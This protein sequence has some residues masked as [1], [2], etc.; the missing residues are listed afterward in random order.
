MKQVLE[1]V[2][3]LKGRFSKVFIA[4]D[5]DPKLV[6]QKH[7]RVGALLAIG[8]V[9]MAC[10]ILAYESKPKKLKEIGASREISSAPIK[11][12]DIEEL[13]K[14]TSN[15]KLWTEGAS[16]EVEAVKQKQMLSEEEQSKLK[17]YIEKDKVS[18]DE[19]NETISQ[20]KAQ[21]EEEYSHKMA[22][23]IEQ[24]KNSTEAKAIENPMEF[25]SFTN[26][27]RIK[28]VGSYIPAGSFVEGKI[29]AGVD[30]SVGMTA[31]ADP[32]IV[33]IR[34]TGKVVSA[35]TA[36]QNNVS[37]RLM[38]CTVLT[39]AIG[40]ISSEK[41]YLQTVVMTCRDNN[42]YIE[43]PIKGYIV[44]Q[45]KAGVR[46]QVVSREGDLV[47]NS[48][49]SG[50]ASGFGNGVAQYS[51]PGMS[52]ASG[53]LVAAGQSG[54]DI[55]LKGLGTG[56]SNSSDRLSDYFIK[57]AEQYQPVISIDGGITIEMVLQEGINLNAEE[58]NEK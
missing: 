10:A 54:K 45:A 58:K 38:G 36:E 48:F 16:K 7:I 13:A 44:A 33:L 1:L 50:I 57:R 39:K 2:D 17:E 18:K 8:V 30:A 22:A 14:G 11:K 43:T 56:V 35:G 51:Q 46:G 53:N 28:V 55:A 40:D 12:I 29:I 19:L 41:V 42:H 3:K 6:R 27:K 26:K 23:V 31:E 15:E 52:F 9:V 32:K 24:L 5:D 37:Q 34:L 49:L 25:K 4:N 47:L 20:F 21:L